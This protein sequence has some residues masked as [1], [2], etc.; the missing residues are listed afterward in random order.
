M[1]IPEQFRADFARMVD[2][3]KGSQQLKLAM[4]YMMWPIVKSKSFQPF[5]VDST[6]AFIDTVIV[7]YMK[8]QVDDPSC[9][10]GPDTWRE[11]FD[12]CLV[13]DA[14]ADSKQCRVRYE[15]DNMSFEDPNGDAIEYPA[16]RP[17]ITSQ[18]VGKALASVLRTDGEQL[19]HSILYGAGTE[20]NP[21]IDTLPPPSTGQVKDYRRI[22]GLLGS[23]GVLTEDEK[24][25][26]IKA[27]S[28]ARRQQSFPALTEN[29][30]WAWF[31]YG[32][33][34]EKE[35]CQPTAA[36]LDM[37]LNHTT[38]AQAFLARR[39]QLVEVSTRA[40][41]ASLEFTS[42]NSLP[43]PLEQEESEA[44]TT[45]P[46][47]PKRKLPKEAINRTPSVGS[48]TVTVPPPEEA[49]ARPCKRMREDEE[50]Q[51]QLS[52]TDKFQVMGLMLKALMAKL[53]KE[54]ADP[55]ECMAKVLQIQKEKG[56]ALPAAVADWACDFA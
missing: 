13:N 10:P 24:L 42:S 27:F 15:D 30:K 35:D 34:G 17:F 25:F 22:W 26:Y 12:L 56:C 43:L 7:P 20:K 55:E 53:G 9:V 36:E 38:S 37:M 11:L 1:D 4:A 32:I 47:P 49:P 29:F 41:S 54:S 2:L 50:Q 18:K 39:Q 45:P 46:P 33:I 14:I 21:T 16:I 44:E 31:R 23:E 48:T 6:A 8:S 5:A 40:K 3:F 52:D 28:L 19:F 51:Q